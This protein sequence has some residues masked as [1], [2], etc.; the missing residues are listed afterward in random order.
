MEPHRPDPGD[1]VPDGN[2]GLDYKD[3][4]VVS[5]HKFIGGP[6]T[7]GVLVARRSLFR[8]RVP[9]SPGGGTVAYVNP[10]EHVYLDDPEHREEGGTPAIVESIRAGLVFALKEQVGV[11]AIRSRE[12]AFIER[13]ISA[14]QEVP[15]LEILGNPALPR[16]SIVSFV[17]RHAGRYLHHNYVVARAER[18]VRDPVARWL[19]VRRAVRP[20]IARDRHRDVSRVRARDRARLRGDQARLDPGE[21]QLLHQRGRVRVPR[22]L[23]RTGGPRGVAT[24]AVVPVR[25]GDGHL[26]PCG[27]VDRAAA[28]PAR[29]VVHRGGCLV[30]VPPPPSR[31]RCARRSPRRGR[32]DLRRPGGGPRCAARTGPPGAR[33]RRF[34]G[35]P[36]VLAAGRAPRG[37]SRLTERAAATRRSSRAD[38]RDGRFHSA[39]GLV[40]W[41]ASH[42]GSEKSMAISTS[43]PSSASIVRTQAFIGGDFVDAA[44]GQDLRGREPGERPA[45]RER[46]RVRRRGRRPGRR[47][48][49]SRGVRAGRDTSPGRAKA[50]PHPVRRPDRRPRATSSPGSRR[51]DVGK[52]ISDS[53]S[54][55]IPD[56]AATI[57]WHAEATDKLYDQVAPTGPARRRRWSCA[58]RWA[59]SARSCPGTTRSRWR[60]GSSAR[61][62]RPATPS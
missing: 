57:R 37:R 10:L 6:G 13:A 45:A 51:L 56:S 47:G 2:A 17:V 41:A 58:S 48:G 15:E 46:R 24:A 3:A 53:R 39:A 21:L 4:I 16:L 44:S 18:P 49:A 27:R 22:R 12:A 11:D 32:A 23:G 8:N 20:P 40:P 35:A 14:W 36:L 62:W 31:R 55:D 54:L 1:D 50:D 26:A 28:V 5:P 19:L 34:R 33:R 61:S 25:P 59:S 7:P 30:S 38:R 42:R 60:P 52:P 43:D 29:R 9:T